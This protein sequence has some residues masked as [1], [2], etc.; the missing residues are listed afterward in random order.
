MTRTARTFDWS[1]RHDPASRNYPIRTLVGP[2]GTV[3]RVFTIWKVGPCLDQ[4]AEGACVGHGYTN[5]ATASPVRVDFTTLD[6]GAE[7]PK[8]PQ[9]FAFALYDWC[10]RND[11]WPGEDYDGTSVLTGAQGMKMLG[12]IPEYRWAFSMEDLIDAL[13]AHGP[14]VLGL[15]WRDGMYDAPGG[16]LTGTGA[17]V[18]GHCILAVGY[19]PE[20]RFS[21]GTVTEAI[22]LF[23]SWGREWGINGLAWIRVSELAGLLENGGEMCVPV[24]RSYGRKPRKVCRLFAAIKGRLRL[25]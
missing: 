23:N 16:E 1:S 7:W 18:G 19:D 3:A 25:R 11:P 2:R 9:A 17:V 8:D 22:A 12:L 20:H 5:E 14:A 21:D 4:A 6:L 13:V 15:E 10:R 24:R